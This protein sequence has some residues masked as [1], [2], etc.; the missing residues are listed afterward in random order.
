MAALRRSPSLFAARTCYLWALGSQP[1]QVIFPSSLILPLAAELKEEEDSP[2]ASL[3]LRDPLSSAF[4]FFLSDSS[5]YPSVSFSSFFPFL[6]FFSLSF[7]FL[8]FLFNLFFVV[9][10]DGPDV[11][12]RVLD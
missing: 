5:L 7:L 12:S 10:M 8:H 4:F 1:L 11:A 6:P 9:V 2:L 3:P